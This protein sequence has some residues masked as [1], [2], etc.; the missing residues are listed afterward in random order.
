MTIEMDLRPGWKGNEGIF[1]EVQV[2][3]THRANRFL[4]DL[5]AARV[6]SMRGMSDFSLWSNRNRDPG[7]CAEVSRASRSSFNPSPPVEAAQP[8]EAHHKATH[9]YFHCRYLLV[10]MLTRVF[11]RF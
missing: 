10:G 1:W 2:L 8:P 9:S 5:Q 11:C 3:L 6:A 4:I 7:F